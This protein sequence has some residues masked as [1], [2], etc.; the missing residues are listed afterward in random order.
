AA[1]LIASGAWQVHA[2]ARLDD[3]ASLMVLTTAHELGAAVWAGGLVHLVAAGRVIR[4]TP[5]LASTWTLL[6]ARF[7]RLAI[8]SVALLLV[9]AAPLAWAYV[10]SW[11]ALVG[12]GYGS[13]VLTKVGLMGAALLV[14]AFNLSAARGRRSAPSVSTTVPALIEA[15]LILLAVLLFAAATL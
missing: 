8:A 7:S 13:L 10:G 12:T 2:A 15:E 9:T 6:L 1:A 5:A 3:R 11:V 4:A 14:A